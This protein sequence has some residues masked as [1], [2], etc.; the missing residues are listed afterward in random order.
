MQLF[1]VTRG[2]K[3]PACGEKG[4]VTVRI[5]C[6]ACGYEACGNVEGRLMRKVQLREQNKNEILRKYKGNGKEV[7]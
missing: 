2:W 3:C 5:T 7:F 6:E 1:P 4:H